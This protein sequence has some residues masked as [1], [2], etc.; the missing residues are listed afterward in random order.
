[1][2]PIY[3]YGPYVHG[4]NKGGLPE[5]IISSKLRGAAASNHMSNNN[6]AVRAYEGSFEFHKKNKRWQGKHKIYIEFLTKQ[7]SRSGMP[8]GG[9][10]WT[11]SQLT[12][13]HLEIK[14]LRVING[15]G[16]EL[17]P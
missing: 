2:D 11:G 7:P 12:N 14:I 17:K 4:L 6:P 9:A 1:M 13:N 16:E 15:D 10:E 3:K 5:I 8:P